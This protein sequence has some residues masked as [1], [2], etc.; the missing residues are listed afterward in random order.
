MTRLH[1]LKKYLKKHFRKRE[2]HA[3]TKNMID[4]KGSRQGDRKDLLSST[5]GSAEAKTLTC[6]I[7][8]IHKSI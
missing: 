6:V 7:A 8:L 3:N 5:Q 1:L 2:A 4:E